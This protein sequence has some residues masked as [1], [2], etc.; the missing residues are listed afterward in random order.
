MENKEIVIWSGGA[1][2]TYLLHTL[3]QKSSK[4]NPVD[5]ISIVYKNFN[6][7]KNK[8]EKDARISIMKW[9]KEKKY[10][11]T[12]REITI[13]TSSMPVLVSNQALEWISC[14]MPFIDTNSNVHFGYIFPD[15][16]WHKRQEFVK[17]FYALNSIKCVSNNTTDLFFDLEWTHKDEIVNKLKKLKLLKLISTCEDPVNYKPC[18]KCEKCLELKNTLEKIKGEKK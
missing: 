12:N 1:D 9:F 7:E 5:T 3:A 17:A 6:E 14:I 10:H 13:N 2:S 15:S 16:F 8:L 18:K 4:E 11:I